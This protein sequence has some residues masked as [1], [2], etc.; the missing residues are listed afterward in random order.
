MRKARTPR[1]FCSQLTSPWK[2]QHIS[3][4]WKQNQ[5]RRVETETSVAVQRHGCNPYFNSNDGN[6]QEATSSTI[7]ST[8]SSPSPRYSFRNLV[9][10]DSQKS[11]INDKKRKKKMRYVRTEMA[12]SGASESRNRK[13]YFSKGVRRQAVAIKGLLYGKGS[14]SE[15]IIRNLLGNSPDTSKALRMCVFFV[16]LIIFLSR[17]LLF[18]L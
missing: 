4:G 7:S 8:V 1:I 6:G 2:I 14:T 18:S 9:C 5:R 15:I 10:R 17:F 3:I 12:L 11:A 13:E 16:L